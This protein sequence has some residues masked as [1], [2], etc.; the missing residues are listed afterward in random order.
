MTFLCLIFCI[1]LLLL[2]LIDTMRSNFGVYKIFA[3]FY[4]FESDSPVYSPPGSRSEGLEI[5]KFSTMSF[6]PMGRSTVMTN[7]SFFE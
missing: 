2:V 3:E 5:I 1:K 7:D 6:L 4:V